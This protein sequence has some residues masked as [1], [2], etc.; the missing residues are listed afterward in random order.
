MTDYYTGIDPDAPAHSHTVTVTVNRNAVG[1]AE[2]VTVILALREGQEPDILDAL[3]EAGE[4]VELN[5]HENLL[6]RCL[7]N[8]GVDETGR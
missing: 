6:A 2:D 8:A 1:G 5:P 7:A 4:P 3:D